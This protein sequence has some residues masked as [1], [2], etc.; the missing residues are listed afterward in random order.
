MANIRGA[1]TRS[2]LGRCRLRQDQR[3]VRVSTS[4]SVYHQASGWRR[5]QAATDPQSLV[6]FTRETHG[7]ENTN[8][9]EKAAQKGGLLLTSVNYGLGGPVGTTGFSLMYISVDQ[10]L[11][12]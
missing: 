9:K 6:P 11:P 7:A 3:P 2:A 10:S 12:G 1:I 8:A 5:P 4:L